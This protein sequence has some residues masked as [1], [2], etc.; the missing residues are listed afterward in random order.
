MPISN[1]TDLMF[2][3]VALTE[4]VRQLYKPSTFIRN[5]FFK[6]E[7]MFS[8]NNIMWDIYKGSRDRASLTD[9]SAES[10]VL[11]RKG[12]KTKTGSIPHTKEKILMT[13]G[14]LLDRALGGN[15]IVRPGDV[16]YRR[17]GTETRDSIEA[18]IDRIV[19]LQEYLCSLA[20]TE[21]KIDI[22]NENITF[23]IDYEIPEENVLE[24]DVEWQSNTADII[25]DI[26]KLVRSVS[27]SSG[28]VPESLIVGHTAFSY[29]IKNKDFKE[30]L[31]N[32]R[33]EMGRIKPEQ[34]PDGSSYCGR[35]HLPEA[36]I[37]IYQYAERTIDDDGNNKYLIDPKK[38]FVGSTRA[39][40]SYV[41]GRVSE[42]DS[43]ADTKISV[44]SWRDFDP[45]GLWIKAE[46]CSMPL[47]S[48]PDAFG[49]MTVVA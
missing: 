35:F 38:I 14:D 25:G 21:G 33:M 5:L 43:E 11:K 37:D 45:S 12:Y 32:L 16:L 1:I 49:R 20:F 9:I 41:W 17:F 13:V 22:N 36:I 6:K 29:M 15:I 44:N 31:D 8:T 42:I 7:K 18:L 19:R 23:K 3:Q 4:V 34:L 26:G 10:K 2:S 40:N 39:Q 48:Q 47:L 24:A 30:N 28:L 46:S 27:E